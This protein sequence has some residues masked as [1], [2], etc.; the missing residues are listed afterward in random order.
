MKPLEDILICE[1]CG[2]E[3]YPDE[4]DL[5]EDEYGKELLECPGCGELYEGF[6][7]RTIDRT[8]DMMARE[9]QSGKKKTRPAFLHM[10]ATAQELKSAIKSKLRKSPANEMVEAILEGVHPADLVDDIEESFSQ[11]KRRRRK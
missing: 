9:A 4:A 7:S 3:F 8:R 2:S 5:F 6:W 1:E 11:K 10:K